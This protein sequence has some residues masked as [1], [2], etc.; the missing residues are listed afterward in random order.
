M[1][2]SILTG[3]I[4]I[5]L[6]SIFFLTYE[7]ISMMF[8]RDGVPN[9]RVHQSAFFNVFIFMILFNAINVRSENYNLFEHIKE[10]KTFILVMVLIFALQVI[11]TY[12][13]GT[14][15]RTTALTLT[16]WA[17]V[18]S[19]ALLIIPVDLIRKF[20]FSMLSTP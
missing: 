17:I 19:M 16:E 7:P 1:V 11:F 3:G 6:F 4:F 10:N 8:V 5:T 12:I 18:Y 2:S 13:G 15:L 20:I 9:L 14:I